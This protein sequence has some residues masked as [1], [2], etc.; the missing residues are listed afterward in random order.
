M[1]NRSPGETHG[2]AGH[3][4]LRAKPG[5][6]LPPSTATSGTGHGAGAAP[7]SQLGQHLQL[8]REPLVEAVLGSLLRVRH[9][10]HRYRALPPAR[11]LALPAAAP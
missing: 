2:G 9:N 10:P 8:V 1:E 7:T 11:P 6:S 4:R 5:R 3:G